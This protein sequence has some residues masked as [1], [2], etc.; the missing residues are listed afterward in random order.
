MKEIGTLTGT[1]CQPDGSALRTK[2]LCNHNATSW[3]HLKARRRGIFPACT[4]RGAVDRCGAGFG[5]HESQGKNTA[6]TIWPV[7]R[8][9]E[10]RTSWG[11]AEVWAARGRVGDE[12]EWQYIESGPRVGGRRE[13]SQ[14]GRDACNVRWWRG[15]AM[16]RAGGKAAPGRDVLE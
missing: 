12:Q 13:A 9:N 16:L 15:V 5:G 1:P 3:W 14:A 10:R 11:I 4:G 8:G 7:A 6:Q 2:L